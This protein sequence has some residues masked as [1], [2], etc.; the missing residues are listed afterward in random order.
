MECVY[1]EKYGEPA[2]E[3]GAEQQMWIVGN[4]TGGGTAL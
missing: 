2:E 1:H 3:G 4:V